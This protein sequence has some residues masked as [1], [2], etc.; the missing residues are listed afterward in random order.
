MKDINT[1]NALIK[2]GGSFA[3]NIGYAAMAA[4]SENYNKLYTAF[5]DLFDEY[6]IRFVTGKNIM[7]ILN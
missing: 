4:D 1:I 6:R 5:K 2:Y 3:K 7:S